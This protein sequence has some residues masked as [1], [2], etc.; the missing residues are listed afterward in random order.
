MHSPGCGMILSALAVANKDVLLVCSACFPVIMFWAL[1]R[2]LLRQERLFRKTH[3]HVRMAEGD[4][5]DFSMNT[6]PFE[7]V[8]DGA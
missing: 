1:D 7:E 3:N 2:Y 5:F 6:Q 4:S 8:V